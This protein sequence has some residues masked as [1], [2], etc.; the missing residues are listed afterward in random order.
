MHPDR[1][2]ILAANR[3]E[4]YARPARGPGAL[5]PGIVGGRDELAGGTWLALRVD[6]AFAAV[7]NQR[8]FAPRDAAAR[9]RG[10]LPLALLARPVREMA[11]FAGALDASEY[12]DGNLM[13]GSAEGVWVAYLRREAR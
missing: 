13:F 8:T 2:V 7:T 9:S 11:A 5:A 6:G 10:E 4:F 3:D 12:N 1:P